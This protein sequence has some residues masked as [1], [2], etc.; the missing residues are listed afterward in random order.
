MA[1]R[2]PGALDAG[3][4]WSNVRDGV[5]SVTPLTDEQLRHQGV[6]DSVLD[7]PRYVKVAAILDKMDQFDPGFF[8]FGA[9]EASMM[10]PQHRQFLEVA[11]EAL[12]NA[13]HDPAQFDG[14]VGVFG[15]SGHNA[16]MPYNLFTNP[17]YMNRH[18]LFLV[19]HTGNDKDFL[20]T[21]VSYC[22]NLTGPSVN[23]QTACSTSLVA[24]HL[25]AQS[26]LSH[27][28]DM[29]LAGGVTIEMPHH[30]GY[31]YQEGEILSPDGHCRPFDANSQ[32]T[33]FG[34]GAGVLVLRRME[35]AL[36]DGDN[37]LAVLKSSAVN[38]DGAG[39]VS[40]MAP[41][42]DGQAAAIHEA[43]MVA[44]INPD[45][46][47]YVECHGT[48]TPI[49]DPIEI[50]ALTSAYQR[51]TDKKQFC[52]VGSVKAN[53]GHL[54][55]A[56]GVASA[57]KVI[58][59]LRHRELPPNINFTAPNPAIDWESSPFYVN[60]QVKPWHRDDGPRRAGVSS[61]GVGGTNAHLIFEE[62]P[63]ARASAPHRSERVLLT[64]SGRTEKA[65]NRNSKK[66]AQ[67]LE[68]HPDV[69]LADLAYTLQTGRRSFG[70]R[71]VL[72]AADHAEAIE[73]LT[74][75]PAD[76]VLTAAAPEQAAEVAF[77]FAGGG[78]QYPGM[79]KDL[80]DTEPV[81]RAAV[82]ECLNHL[83]DFIDFDL[84]S[85]MYPAPDQLESARAELERPTRSLTSLFTAQYAQAKLWMSWG[86]EPVCLTGHSM[87]E[88]TA[89]CIAGVISL[90]D[91]VGLVALRGQLF[92]TV[93]EGGMLS[94][95]AGE[96]RLRELMDN[97]LSLACVN[98]PE[99]SVVSGPSESLA[100]LENTLNQQE[101]EFQRVRINIAAHSSMLEPILEAFGD[102]LRSMELSAPKI[103]LTAN[104]TGSWMTDEQATD[105]DYWVQHL[106]HTVRFADCAE[107]LLAKPNLTLLEVGPGKTLSSLCQINPAN[108]VGGG[109]VH[110]MRHP[111][112][113]ESDQAFML[114][115]FG[116]LWQAGGVSD[117]RPYWDGERRQR[118]ALPTYSFDH[119]RY[120]V[121]P[122]DEVFSEGNVAGLKREEDIAHWFYQ[123]VWRRA[124][125]LPDT[126]PERTQQRIMVVGDGQEAR[127][128]ASRIEGRAAVIRATRGAELAPADHGF[129][130]PLDQAEA[131]ADLL[132]GAAQ[133]N[134][135]P[136]DVVVFVEGDSTADPVESVF[137]PLFALVKAVADEDP[138][139]GMT[140]TVVTRGLFAVGA[141][142][143]AD[144]G[145]ALALGPVGVANRELRSV[146]ARLVDLEA[147]SGSA[148]NWLASL[149]REILVR[150]A[151][152]PD[153]ETG[154]AVIALRNG[155]RFVSGF[156]AALPPQG[157]PL[158]KL[159]DNDTVV[160]TG[161]IGGLALVVAE[162]LAEQAKLNLVLVSRRELPPTD[163]WETLAEGPGA[164]A[165][166]FKTL[167]SISKKATVTHLAADISRPDQVTSL[168]ARIGEQFGPVCGV[169]HTAG[170]IDDALIQLKEP[171]DARRVLAPK[172]Q[173]TRLLDQ[174]FAGEQL[175]FF[176]AFSSISAFAGLPGQIDYAAA[177]AYLDSYCAHRDGTN[178]TAYTAI[179]WPAWR[180]VG[181][182][183]SIADG[184][185][186][187]L[188]ALGE[189][190]THPML[191]TCVT[192]TEERCEFI[193][194]FSPDTDWVL[195]EHRLAASNDALIPGAGY[196]ELA[197]AAFAEATG[198]STVAMANVFFMAPFFVPDGDRRALK[199]VV[200]LA[201]GEFLISSEAG[202]EWTEHCRGD[203]T[204]AAPKSISA[205]PR[206]ELL[207]RCTERV[208]RFD[209]A[210][211]HPHLNFGPRWASLK[212]IHLGQ[213][214]ALEEIDLGSHESD[215]EHYRLHPAMLDM[216][217]AGAQAL[218]PGYQP[219]DELYVP[220][221]Y[222]N[223]TYFG[224]TA[225]RWYS[226]V[227]YREQEASEGRAG[228]SVTFDIVVTDEAGTPLLM[229]QNFT[230]QRLAAA[231]SA[232]PADDELDPALKRTLELGISPKEGATAFDMALRRVG[233]PQ[234]AVAAFEID[235]MVQQLT[236]S[237]GGGA[238]A[239]VVADS[240]HD[241]DIDPDIP[242]I[243]AAML[244]HEAIELAV[245]RSHLDEEDERRLVAHFVVDPD[246]YVTVSDLRRH[247]K[248]ELAPE[249]L[250][251]HLI[252]ID[253]IPLD[254]SGQPKRK[255]LTD[256]FAPVDTFEAPETPTQKAIVAI[257]QE[258]LDVDRIGVD[259]NFFD[260]GGHSLL[261]IRAITKTNKKFGV[262]LNQAIMALQT[263]EQVAAEVD[264]QR[265][266]DEVDETAAA[267]PA[268]TEPDAS[269]EPE[270]EKPAQRRGLVK[271]LFG[272]RS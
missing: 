207:A 33:L 29:A 123:P 217:T 110:S 70:Q 42:V 182:A 107:A 74:Q 26:L 47:D 195:D 143:V 239:T 81:Y 131:W 15:G 71:R 216:A 95:Q 98:A 111:D 72:A 162:K 265:G 54:D 126:A 101:I 1:C 138:E 19:R 210:D 67:Y 229:V 115:M 147:G 142:T 103:P 272:K 240:G 78:A 208:Q 168:R 228:D 61:L 264:S 4:F 137:Q 28:C 63:P 237:G 226:H 84:K 119:A 184:S 238:R 256:P 164:L 21:R 27:E 223:L 235:L 166:R 124:G 193:K 248:A 192:R 211:H 109:I 75:Q 221:G 152:D 236:Q 266:I 5:E 6:P 93:P 34:S 65:L 89:A 231:L 99:L 57:I 12:E 96:E 39:K 203:I 167:L 135:L 88:N 117:F 30:R 174:A 156:D 60:A 251:Q 31:T 171:A 232:P 80:Y 233:L 79:G 176:V 144:P 220:V 8:G 170:V 188:A 55:T 172:V 90:R 35:D 198:Q 222:Q 204:P 59:A 77:M 160:I 133:S 267:P 161:G 24:M 201:E 151:G 213:G 255:L 87:G 225:G 241:A 44:D 169:V 41:S 190:V 260:L 245:V 242:V 186:I 56:A 127:A 181:M 129:S 224:A 253:E 14:A 104:L 271:S 62:A 136:T 153:E 130:L 36:A 175:R 83:K 134:E 48:G 22:F 179:N 191:G 202:R 97:A 270:A 263:L 25:A 218:I 185:A 259:E 20:T 7:D 157:A 261:S 189:A 2:L 46:I 254:S 269:A 106:R 120:W 205:E 139:E 69:P 178:G 91:A 10:D 52:G 128:L 53:I 113:G 45:S 51:E 257:W 3:A 199:V 250:P 159:R 94:V 219:M 64:V 105:P 155:Q 150:A 102:Y 262:Q 86:V 258:V 187:E 132:A 197:R 212:A 247:L 37:I 140:I 32:G 121:E 268:A 230:M 249:L 145:Q 243:E 40:Y 215:L 194:I 122:G 108:T 183:A 23:V 173:G 17:Q 214:E 114:R 246:E 118:L 158:V 125:R 100:A 209:E 68:T 252:E 206:S 196:I 11:W 116:A 50:A 16:Y 180:Q 227:T 18:G 92:E 244:D 82:D 112:D 73:L 49:G 177:N 66:L 149:E 234:V 200:D 146:E 141:E 163:E 165:K 38:N 154:D 58:Q 85:L 9:L 13:G 76:R 148:G 43:L